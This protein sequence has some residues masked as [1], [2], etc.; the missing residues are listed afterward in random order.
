LMLREAIER[1]VARLLSKGGDKRRL[2]NLLD[3]AIDLDQHQAKRDPRDEEGMQLHLKFHLNLA[4]ATGFKSLEETLYRLWGRHRFVVSWISSVL[5]PV[6]ADWHQ[7]LVKVIMVGD[8]NL[9]DEK[10]REH[11]TYGFE[12]GSESLATIK[13]ELESKRGKEWQLAAG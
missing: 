12:S 8:S 4:R 6:P 11:V 5:H 1:Q 10:M 7:Q 13:K 9:A 3:D 2:S